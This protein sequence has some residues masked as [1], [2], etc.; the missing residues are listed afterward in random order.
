MSFLL[1]A[2]AF[3]TEHQDANDISVVQAIG[4]PA[5]TRAGIKL[6]DFKSFKP[7]DQRT[8]ITYREEATGKLKRVTR[9]ITNMIIEL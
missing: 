4:D 9:G 1:A 7:V 2:Y 6:L 8:E 5:R 3:R